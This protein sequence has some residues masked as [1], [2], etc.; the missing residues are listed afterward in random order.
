MNEN[1]RKTYKQMDNKSL[2]R[3]PN[4]N[5]QQKKSSQKMND[6]Y[7]EDNEE[8]IFHEELAQKVIEVLVKN[9]TIDD[10]LSTKFYVMSS[11]ILCI[12][13]NTYPP[14]EL[15]FVEYTI[16]KGILQNYHRFIDVGNVPIGY[17]YSALSHHENCHKIPIKD[18]FEAIDDYCLI[19]EEIQQLLAESRP[20][21]VSKTDGK[22]PMIVFSDGEQIKQNMGALEWLQNKYNQNLNRSGNELSFKWDIKVIDIAFLVFNIFTK[23]GNSRPLAIC[24]SDVTSSAFDYSP[25]TDCPFHEDLQCINCAV[26]VAKRMCYMLSVMFKDIFKID[27]T[28]QHFPQI[29][30]MPVRTYL[31][32]KSV[33]IP[34]LFTNRKDGNN[35]QKSESEDT[36]DLGLKHK[37]LGIGRGK[38]S[39]KNISK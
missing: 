7:L 28:R 27:I 17:S 13:D 33:D 11:N 26:G 3:M 8:T 32:L 6:P 25:D 2:Q 30:E 38:T 1:Q 4:E 24:R 31:D 37:S 5:N 16:E 12:C 36:K 23:M 10:L 9:K 20:N 34:K 29:E 21:D 18:F 15:G 39:R 14:I 19:V 35:N 22:N